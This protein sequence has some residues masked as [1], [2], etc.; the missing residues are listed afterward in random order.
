MFEVYTGHKP[1]RQSLAVVL[2]GAL[3]IATL[4]LALFQSQQSRTLGD[5]VRIPGTRLTVRP[6]KDW[7]QMPNQPN[8]FILTA[9]EDVGTDL[10]ELRARRLRF[11]S[12]Q[13]GPL[14][15]HRSGPAATEDLSGYMPI[16]R[17]P[18]P[19]AP[20][21]G[22]PAVEQIWKVARVAIFR[23]R[24]VRYEQTVIV[25]DAMSPAGEYIHVEYEPLSELPS[26]G[27]QL[28]LDAVCEAIRYEPLA[29]VAD[30]LRHAGV[31]FALA[32]GWQAA[33]LDESLPAVRI[34]R[35]GGM[36]ATVELFRTVLPN[37][38][39]VSAAMR[40]LGRAA[41]RA[42]P[43]F[44]EFRAGSRTD[45]TRVLRAAYRGTRHASHLRS[46]W[47]VVAPD[48]QA[49]ALLASAPEGEIDV[50]ETAAED[51]VENVELASGAVEPIAFEKL[52][53]LIG[54]GR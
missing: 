26:A 21:A 43:R 14:A 27:D 20:I 46:A 6:P 12:G 22:M 19:V 42:S 34:S 54:R 3:L 11:F 39:D 44:M 30:P 40:L 4:G 49:A 48:G 38:A 35:A 5:P 37:D 23:R 13:R 45:G 1:G 32:A 31:E 10:A 29:A 25:R 2:S 51:I 28:L 18:E 24:P 7:R 52:L 17:E 9:D 47:L 33:A 15:S 8:T 50:L 16:T 53:E 36:D 41:W